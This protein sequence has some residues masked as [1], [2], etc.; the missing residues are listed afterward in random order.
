MTG[1]PTSPG[2][3]PPRPWYREP[4]PWVLIA[5]PAITVVAC[6]ITLY[7]ALTHPD[8][9]VVD[10]QRYEQV[11]AEMRGASTMAGGAAPPPAAPAQDHG[12][13]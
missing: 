12:A 5:I 6:A 9:V 8:T 2:T 13:H 11:R 7:L 3:P 1:R 10:M 4:W